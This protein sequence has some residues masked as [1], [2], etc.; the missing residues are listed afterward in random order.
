MGNLNYLFENF[1]SLLLA[2]KV[3]SPSSLLSLLKHPRQQLVRHLITVHKEW[4]GEA[5][6]LGLKSVAKWDSGTGGGDFT[7]HATVPAPNHFLTIVPEHSK[8][9]TPLSKEMNRPSK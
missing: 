3:V 9:T 8:V 1:F 2:D 5:L 7:Y 6:Q 4:K